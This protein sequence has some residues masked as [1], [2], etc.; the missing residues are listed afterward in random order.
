MAIFIVLL[1]SLVNLGQLICALMPGFMKNVGIYSTVAAF[2]GVFGEITAPPFEWFKVQHLEAYAGIVIVFLICDVT[3]I[4]KMINYM[5]IRPPSKKIKQEKIKT[6]FKGYIYRAEIFLWTVG[7]IIIFVVDSI[8]FH[9]LTTANNWVFGIIVGLIGVIE[10]V[11]IF[12]GTSFL[13][14]INTKRI[15]KMRGGELLAKDMIR[16]PGIWYPEVFVFSIQPFLYKIC[17]LI[18]YLAFFKNSYFL[19]HSNLDW[20]IV[21]TERVSILLSISIYFILNVI[22]IL[23][24]ILFKIMNVFPENFRLAPENAKYRKQGV[25]NTLLENQSLLGVFKSEE[26]AKKKFL[27]LS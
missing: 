5:G 21:A 17:L 4:I 7:I 10:S 8:G 2:I 6:L 20:R 27:V 26:D 15:I 12:V 1:Y 18:S 11:I 3:N 16:S 14:Y 13:I 24:K 22:V 23:G 25:I 9:F 19:N